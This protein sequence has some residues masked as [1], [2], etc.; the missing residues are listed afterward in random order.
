MLR[1]AEFV[2]S[3][4][5]GINKRTP[6]IIVA[7]TRV[8]SLLQPSVILHELIGA[9]QKACVLI[10]REIVVS[11]SAAKLVGTSNIFC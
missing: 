8:S 3:N 9:E 10:S 2:D 5:R 11:N 4:Y 1:A 6:T 7:V